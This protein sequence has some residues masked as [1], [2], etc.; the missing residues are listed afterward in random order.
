MLN[1]I[2]HLALVVGFYI[3][4]TLFISALYLGNYVG[5]IKSTFN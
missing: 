2:S 5:R 1:Y 4:R 3:A